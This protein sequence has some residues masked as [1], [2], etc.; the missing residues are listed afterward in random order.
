MPDYTPHCSPGWRL[1]LAASVLLA[2]FPLLDLLPVI[3]P[4]G[5]GPGPTGEERVRL[6]TG[7]RNPS[8]PLRKVH[9]SPAVLHVWVTNT[10][11]TDA[12][13]KGT[14]A[15]PA[16]EFPPFVHAGMF[17][18]MLV[19]QECAKG[20]EGSSLIPE[21]SSGAAQDRETSSLVISSLKPVASILLVSGQHCPTP[22]LLPG[23]SH[24]RRSLV[25]YSPCCDIISCRKQGSK[26]I[27]GSGNKDRGSFWTRGQSLQT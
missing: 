17:T 1:R 9:S 2:V 26:S 6:E 8:G 19:G 12:V 13:S 3:L 24:G 7:Y 22:V 23:K 20:L 21:A 14:M 18:H 4:P 16:T 15:L 5:A 27:G 10:M 25:S 11:A